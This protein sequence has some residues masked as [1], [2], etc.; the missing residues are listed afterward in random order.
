MRSRRSVERRL[1]DQERELSSR[2]RAQR[3]RRRAARDVYG[4][5]GFETMWRDGICE[6]ERGLFSQTVSFTDVSYQSA[7]QAFSCRSPTPPSRRRRS[8]TARSS[9]APTP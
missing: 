4:A 6:V 1:R 9:T 2:T 7:R 8:A 3:R 5:I